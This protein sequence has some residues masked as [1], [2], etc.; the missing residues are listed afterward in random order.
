MLD[1]SMNDFWVNR[2]G[3]SVHNSRSRCKWKRLVESI[4]QSVPIR[5]REYGKDNLVEWNCFKRHIKV[6]LMKPPNNEGDSVPISH[7]LS[8]NKTSRNDTTLHPVEMMAKGV[9]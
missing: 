9:P 7:R 5:Y 3:N 6:M 4:M 8:P 1:D 2:A